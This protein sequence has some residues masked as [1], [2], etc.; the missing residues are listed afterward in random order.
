[1]CVRVRLVQSEILTSLPSREVLISYHFRN[2][3]YNGSKILSVLK[4]MSQIKKLF[5]LFFSGPRNYK[6]LLLRSEV[7]YRLNH[8]QSSLADAE[9]AIE[10]RPT[11]FNVRSII[12][13]TTHDVFSF[14][15]EF[16]YILYCLTLGIFASR[17]STF[18]AGL[19][20]KS[21]YVVLYVRTL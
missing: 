20:R 17:S 21:N 13:N 15:I 14:W 1:M 10:C 7:L 8:F 6:T 11:S 5:C 2:R 12:T 16:T 3:N 4:N 18:C 9:K 19:D